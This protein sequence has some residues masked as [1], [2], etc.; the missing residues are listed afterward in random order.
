L[1]LGTSRTAKL[2]QSSRITRLSLGLDYLTLPYLP[3]ISVL[4]TFL[5]SPQ[6]FSFTGEAARVLMLPV[7]LIDFI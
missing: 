7:A 2:S 4:D 3:R 5:H 1:N 6:T